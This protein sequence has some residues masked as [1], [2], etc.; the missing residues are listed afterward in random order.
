M[1]SPATAVASSDCTVCVASATSTWPGA[2]GLPATCRPGEAVPRS[3]QLAKARP[4]ESTASERP[5]NGDWPEA[6]PS[7]LACPGSSSAKLDPVHCRTNRCCV[8]DRSPMLALDQASTSVPVPFASTG[9]VLMP[10]LA[11]TPGPLSAPAP[12]GA[13]APAA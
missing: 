1:T 8:A 11:D 5:S 6:T 3:I 12:A 10:T 7:P 13:Q 2:T 4:A 9:C